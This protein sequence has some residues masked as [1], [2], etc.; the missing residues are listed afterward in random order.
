[1]ELRRSLGVDCEFDRYGDSG[2]SWELDDH[3][4]E[5]GEERGV[6]DH[7]GGCDDGDDPD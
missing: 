4:D 6:G 2:G 3:G 7:G 5:R 1:M